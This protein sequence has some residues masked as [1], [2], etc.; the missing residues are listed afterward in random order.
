MSEGREG[1]AYEISEEE[2]DVMLGTILQDLKGDF[3]KHSIQSVKLPDD[4]RDILTKRK[5]EDPD[6]T[7]EEMRAWNE[8]NESKLRPQW[9]GKLFGNIENLA[10]LIAPFDVLVRIEKKLES[11]RR[12]VDKMCKKPGG[13]S[14]PDVYEIERKSIELLEELHASPSIAQKDKEKIRSFID[15]LQP[16]NVSAS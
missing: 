16:E 1:G 11:Y 12:Q 7:E 9:T 10:T 15:D 14:I 8:H 5:L 2:K 6:L 13:M 4:K 3:T